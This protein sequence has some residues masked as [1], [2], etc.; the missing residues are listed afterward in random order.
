MTHNDVLR[1]L[2]Y[3]FDYDDAKMVSIFAAAGRD[4][5]QEQIKDWLVTEDNPR[6]KLLVHE[7]LAAFLNGLINTLRGKRPGPPPPLETWLNNN[8]I[9]MK[10]RIALSLQGEDMIRILNL[11]G[12]ELSN[13]E[14][15]AFFRKPDHKHYRVLKDQVMRCFLRGLQETYRPGGEHDDEADDA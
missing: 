14:L 4:V 10:L 1:R 15:S 12:V 6:Y 13:H 9:V 5:T 3:T 7:E 8:G 11:G 2:R